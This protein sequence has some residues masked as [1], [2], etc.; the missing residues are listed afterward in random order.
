MQHR[1][2]A[3]LEDS[4]FVVFPGVVSP[5]KCQRLATAYDRAVIAARAPDLKTSRAGSSVRLAEL[6]KYGTA[7]DDLLALEPVAEACELVIGESFKL[8]S[9]GAR[10]VLP[11]ATEQALHVDVRIEQDAWPLVGFI[12]MVDG[13]RQDNG[14]T[15]FVPGS[16]KWARVWKDATTNLRPGHDHLISACGTAGSV[17]V[18]DGSTWHGHGAN[19]T[20]APR[21]SIHG[22]YIPR[23]GTAAVKWSSMARDELGFPGEAPGDDREE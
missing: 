1:H 17:I 15:R 7:F 21:R 22:A 16:H 18:F 9:F 23:D 13:F 11:G 20:K 3:A 12:V 6:F 10:T 8:S 5:E 4:G 19:L 14:A 2:R